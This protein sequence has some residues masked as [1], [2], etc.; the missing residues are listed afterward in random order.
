MPN[1][2]ESTPELGANQFKS[3]RFNQELPTASTTT[4]RQKSTSEQQAHNVIVHPR[5]RPVPYKPQ[6]IYSQ[7]Q[8]QPYV[9][10][11]HSNTTFYQVEDLPVNRRG[12]KYKLSR[13][14]PVFQSNHYATTDLAPFEACISLFD[15]STGVLFSR[16]CK[17]ITTAQGW[18]SAR[19]NV[20]IRQGSYYFECKIVNANANADSANADSNANDSAHVRI[21]LAKREA[22]LEAPVG[23][24]GY[25]YGLR[26]IDGYLVFTSRRKNVCIEGGFTTGDVVGF[27]VELPSLKEQKLQL[28]RYV[29]EKRSEMPADY[30]V[31]RRKTKKKTE[32]VEDNVR[33]NEYDNIVRDQIPTKS[34][35]ALYYDQFEYTRTKTMDHLL[36]PVTVFGEKAIIEMDDKTKNIPVIAGSKIRVFKNGKE[37]TAI[38][39]LYAFLPTNIEDVDEI[40]L[41]ANVKQSSNPNYR[42]TDDNTLGYYPMLSVFGKG[43]VTLNAGPEFDFPPSDDATVKPL[44]D[45][46]EEQVIEEWFWDILDEV[47]AQYLDSFDEIS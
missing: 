4:V 31:K 34:K 36:N 30:R 44:S 17:T 35:G 38:E 46:Y 2:I 42:N 41:E 26:D 23:Y 45:R 16:D 24:D 39:N 8:P 32:A 3:A 7:A 6:D 37:C 29:E 12:F 33:F 13:P 5:L 27:L 14:S 47:E 20:G 9:S 1:E 28:E 25:G 22:S 21:G 19:A 10:M 15:R 43:A 11:T 40:N 18:R